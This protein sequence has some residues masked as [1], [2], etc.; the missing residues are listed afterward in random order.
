MASASAADLLGLSN[1]AAPHRCLSAGVAVRLAVQPGKVTDTMTAPPNLTVP[2]R[3]VALA[4]WLSTDL[5]AIAIGRRHPLAGG[6]DSPLVERVEVTAVRTT[7]ERDRFEVVAK[8]ASSAEVIA[9]HEIATVPAA[10]A[11][12]ELI[13][14]GTDGSGP[15]VVTPFYPGS[16]LPWDAEVPEVVFASLARLHHRYLGRSSR[17]PV[18]LPRVDESFCRHALMD[19]ASS[20]IHDA[21]RKKPH[22]V[23]DRALDLLHRWSR[24][25]RIHVGL[26]VLPAALL[27]GDVYGHNVVVVDDEGTRPRL[28]DWGSAR[29]GPIMLD[30][31]LSAEASSGGFSAYLRAWEEVAGCPLDPWQAEAGHAWATAFSNA[32]FVGAVAARFGPTHAE[33]MLDKAEAALERFGQLLAGVRSLGS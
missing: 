33:K 16:T 22:P 27:H 17:L 23:H 21:R 28:I 7:G 12:P 32:M 13:D 3:E 14:A 18:D 30:V 25:E 8:R 31:A 19:F 6:V 15:W 9:L 5:D 4:R 2:V 10:D 29:V 1:A 20:W 26:H 24:D 11:F